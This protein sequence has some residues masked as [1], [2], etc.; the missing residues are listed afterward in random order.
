MQ[1]FQS[2]FAQAKAIAPPPVGTI[3]GRSDL[4]GIPYFE[5]GSYFLGDEFQKLCPSAV[6]IGIGWLASWTWHIN[7][8]GNNNWVCEKSSSLMFPGLPNVRPVSS[9]FQTIWNGPV[10]S[11]S[12][13]APKIVSQ[14]LG[15]YG[16]IYIITPEDL[17][18]LN[19]KLYDRTKL[20]QRIECAATKVSKPRLESKY[21]NLNMHFDPRNTADAFI[22]LWK[23]NDEKE[24]WKRGLGMLVVTPSSS[25]TQCTRGNCN[26]TLQK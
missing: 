23:N 10:I 11:P 4:K 18:V 24:K 20:V 8:R 22:D 17:E 2:V 19:V 12:T 9:K 7:A 15:T 14:H 26:G 3:P 5:Y 1:H 13:W 6:P 21:M 16:I 25:P